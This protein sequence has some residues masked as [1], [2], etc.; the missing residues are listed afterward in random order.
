MGLGEINN[1]SVEH[2]LVLGPLTQE[3]SENPAA[4]AA[5]Y[6]GLES[7]QN[8]A[9]VRIDIINR[10]RGAGLNI[11]GSPFNLNAALQSQNAAGQF[12]GRLRGP[13]VSPALPYRQITGIN[14]ANGVNIGRPTMAGSF[15]P[16]TGR[17]LLYPG[18]GWLENYSTLNHEAAHSFTGHNR[19]GMGPGFGY[20]EITGRGE[21]LRYSTTG[22]YVVGVQRWNEL[23]VQ[24]R[25]SVARALR[26]PANSG[27]A[28][29]LWNWVARTTEAHRQVRAGGFALTN[30]GEMGPILR[31]GP[32]IS[33]QIAE[34]YGAHSYVGALPTE[35]GY[36]RGFFRVN[37]TGSR[38]PFQIF[39]RNPATAALFPVYI[40]N[41]LISGGIDYSTS[42]STTTLGQLAGGA[43]PRAIERSTTVST[44]VRNMDMAGRSSNPFGGRY[45]MENSVNA[46]GEVFSPTGM[47]W[48]PG[49]REIAGELAGLASWLSN[50]ERTRQLQPSVMG[51]PETGFYGTGVAP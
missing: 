1:Y 22:Q 30:T 9:G 18:L 42:T 15:N 8:T 41:D 31:S 44:E 34:L 40:G 37:V 49:T 39:Q 3:Q 29:S 48:G 5:F 19:P 17:I 45:F 6:A 10:L 7:A 26:V 16:S 27:Y 50:L 13:G 46:L 12:F 32:A 35:R 24:Q 21:F 43:D 23:S 38:T 36:G 2:G 33:E 4:A 20:N 25:A 11:P 14:F 28:S 51:S 47:V